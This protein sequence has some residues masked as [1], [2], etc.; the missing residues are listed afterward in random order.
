[1]QD[2]SVEIAPITDPACAEPGASGYN[3][4]D[5]KIQGFYASTTAIRTMLPATASG[6]SR[7]EGMGGML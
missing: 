4:E 2:C 6:Y 1:M 3:Y 7:C 5:L